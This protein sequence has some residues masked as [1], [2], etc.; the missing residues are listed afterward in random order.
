MYVW[1][2]YMMQNEETRKQSIYFITMYN[3]NN[4]L[5][6]SHPS[7]SDLVASLQQ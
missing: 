7:L 3:S 6:L 5:V 4:A 1:Q 2:V